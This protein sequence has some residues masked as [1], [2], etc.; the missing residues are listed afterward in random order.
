M[1]LRGFLLMRREEG[2][3]EL[4]LRPINCRSI[5]CSIIHYLFQGLLIGLCWVGLYIYDRHPYLGI[6]CI[7]ISPGVL[8]Y[9]LVTVDNMSRRFILRSRIRLLN[10]VLGNNICSVEDP[11]NS[12]CSICLELIDIEQRYTKLQC[13]HVYHRDC[14]QNWLIIRASCPLCRDEIS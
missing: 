7:S 3:E 14:I 8:L 9:Y 11:V 4:P 1:S 10:L 2:R 6:I 12:D 13:N 5:F